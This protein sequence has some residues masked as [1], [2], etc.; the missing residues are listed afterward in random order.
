[1]YPLSNETF[2]M[3]TLSIRALL[4]AAASLLV[5]SGCTD[6]ATRN[7]TIPTTPSTVSITHAHGLAV[8]I[9]DP[10]KLYIATHEGL[11]MLQNDK[12]LTRISNSTDDY[13]GFALHPTNPQTFFSSGHPTTGG[14]VGFQSST[15]GGKSWTKISDGIN[16]P[17]DFHAMTVSAA[18]PAIV[19]GWYNHQI[20]ESLDGGVTWSLLPA[21]PGNVISLVN[22]TKDENTVFATTATGIMASKNMGKTWGALSPE[23]SGVVTSLAL[24]PQDPREMFSF[25]E[26]KGLARSSDGGTTWTTSAKGVEGTVVLFIAYSKQDPTTLYLLTKGSSI[27]KTI[28]SGASWTKIR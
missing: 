18:N 11:M 13:M 23:L 17:V 9:Q 14:N 3:K 4:L 7:Q 10:K 5:L 20:Q 8:D 6:G 15:D 28:N 2:F 27:Y 21:S 22:D 26:D 1:M 19:Y 25:S 16:G 12:D 24:N